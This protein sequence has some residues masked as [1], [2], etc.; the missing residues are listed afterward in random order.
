M[1]IFK[2]S[3]EIMK[4]EIFM[5]QAWHWLCVTLVTWWIFHLSQSNCYSKLIPVHLLTAVSRNLATFYWK[6]TN[7][8]GSSTVDY[9]LIEHSH[10]HVAHWRDNF[11]WV[12]TYKYI[13]I[14]GFELQFFRVS[15]KA[16][17]LLALILWALVNSAVPCWLFARRKLGLVECHICIIKIVKFC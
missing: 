16:I 7:W 9:S 3:S 13:K 6:S 12:L 15:T 8:I 1:V 4:D 2:L 17:R 10:T 11:S 5:S 14:V